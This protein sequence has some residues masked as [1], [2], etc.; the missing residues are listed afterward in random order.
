MFTR[1]TAAALLC[2]VNASLIFVAHDASAHPGNLN[3]HFGSSG[4]A[5]YSPSGYVYDVADPFAIDQGS[6]IVFGTNTAAGAMVAV[7]D[8]SGNPDSSFAT[9]GVLSLDGQFVDVKIDSKNRIVVAQ[10][11]FDGTNADVRVSRFASDGSI[12]LSFGT[13]GS[14]AISYP[15]CDLQSQ[16]ITLDADDNIVAAA[17]KVST[18][19]SDVQMVVAKFLAD[20]SVDTKFATGGLLVLSFAPAGSERS[21]PQALTA[22]PDGSIYLAGTT[23]QPSFDTE[24]DVVKIT[25]D[26]LLS[27]SFGH[28]VGYIQFDA[29]PTAAFSHETFAASIALDAGG[30]ILLGGYAG[31]Y[32]TVF[33]ATL[34]ARFLPNGDPDPAFNGGTPQLAFAGGAQFNYGSTVLVDARGSILLTGFA[35]PDID[36][37]PQ[38][39]AFRFISTG[40]LDSTFGA[41]GIGYTVLTDAVMNGASAFSHRGD[42]AM[43]GNAS[44]GGSFIWDELIGYDPPPLSPPTHF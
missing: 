7:L 37:D 22:G 6:R 16:A 21:L 38:L 3:S 8:A 17:T 41:T 31:D 35:F 34:A 44:D 14:A 12:D 29:L 39:F 26:G 27:P 42:I 33:S 11:G 24:T 43:L 13:S 40:A 36:S 2:S 18:F 1:T 20:G 30:N 4:S 32:S 19:A 10:V 5:V 23:L 28:G 9:D 15:G 25:P